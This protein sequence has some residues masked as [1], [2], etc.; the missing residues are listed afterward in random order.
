MTYV[1]C[2]RCGRVMKIFE[3][4]RAKSLTCS[5]DFKGKLDECFTETTAEDYKVS[6]YRHQTSGGFVADAN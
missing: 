3:A 1:K 6:R 2:P 5:C 4:S